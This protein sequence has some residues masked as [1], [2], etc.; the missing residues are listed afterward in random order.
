MVGMRAKKP[1]TYTTIHAYL[2]ATGITL[3]DLSDRVGVGKSMLSLV[4]RGLRQPS[5]DLAFRIEQETGVP[6]SSFRQRV[7]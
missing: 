4:A 5:L 7:A 2:D 1:A 6:A 3:T